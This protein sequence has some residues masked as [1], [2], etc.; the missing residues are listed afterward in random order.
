MFRPGYVQPQPGQ[1]S[2]TALY[3]MMYNVV[4]PLYPLL[5]RVAPDHVTTSV[6]IG[7]AMIQVASAGHSDTVLKAKDINALAE[8]SG[9]AT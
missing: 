3:R 8:V 5:R 6:A 2:K 1:P 9:D 4:A 7:Q